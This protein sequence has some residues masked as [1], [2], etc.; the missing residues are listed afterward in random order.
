MVDTAMQHHSLGVYIV[1]FA[2]HKSWFQALAKA[3]LLEFDVPT[4]YSDSFTQPRWSTDRFVVF[5]SR[6]KWFGRM[7]GTRRP[8]RFIHLQAI[9]EIE[10]LG[11]E[12]IPAIPFLISRSSPI[13]SPPIP[14]NADTIPDAAPFIVAPGVVP[15]TAAASTWNPH[16]FEAAAATF[17]F[18]DIRDIAQSAVREGID[19]YHGRTDKAVFHE[20]KR[21]DSSFALRCREQY[22]ADVAKGFSAG[23][24]P[25]CPFKFA[26]VCWWFYVMKD[27][28]NP[29]D[30]R[31]RLISHHSKGDKEGYG[32]VNSLCTSPR[33]IGVHHSALTLKTLIAI[34]GKGAQVRA[35]DI[36]SCFKR[37]RVNARLL[38]L[39]VYKVVTAE[40]GE[41]F[42][43]DLST[44]FGWTPAEWSWQCILAILMWHFF[45]VH[46][47]RA[48]I[49]YVDNFFLIRP[50]AYAID[51][52]AEA[53]ESTFK[54]LGLPIHEKQFGPQFK[55]LGWEF[56]TDHMVMELPLLKHARF[57]EML[58][59]WRTEKSMSVEEIRKAVGYMHNLSAGFIVGKPLVAFM[60]HMQTQG[61][62]RVQ[63]ERK[64][65]TEVRVVLDHKASMA[66]DVWARVFTWWDRKCPIVAGFTP[67]SAFQVLIRPDASTH[68]GCGAMLWEHNATSVRGFLHEWHSAER[69]QA[70]LKRSYTAPL[71]PVEQSELLRESTSV[72]EALGVL[73]ALQH[74][75]HECAG[76]RVQVELDNSAVVLALESMYTKKPVLMAVI[77]QIADLCCKHHISIRTRFIVGSIFNL[78]ADALSHNDVTQAEIACRSMFQLPLRVEPELQ[79]AAR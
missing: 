44:P 5:V 17:P 53:V 75:V 19:P 74:F 31:I 37:Q 12:K 2:P 42:F 39:F 27:K 8:E 59:R 69:K 18:A 72:F 52:E 47:L 1:P 56:D 66:L 30:S 14:L 4:F 57:T 46:S 16:A 35:W 50:R 43:V 10:C 38:H 73:K 36:P 34:C 13:P 58:A 20:N 78:V 15:P 3:S 68:W 7:K 25:S 24:F 45:V 6:F 76:R 28:N 65:A 21:M 60:R 11:R 71:G 32:S 55:G 64:P 79:S 63:A 41:E 54:K 23:P 70:K 62:K 77:H 33:M 29:A 61:D 51:A 67:Q 49:A 22:V 9:P 48:L 40:F 26:R